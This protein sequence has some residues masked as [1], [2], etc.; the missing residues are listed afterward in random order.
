MAGVGW[1]VKNERGD[2][3]GGEGMEARLSPT[4]G[5]G[6][7]ASP[8]AAGSSAQ[9]DV[10]DAPCSHASAGESRGGAAAALII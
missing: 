3:A 8:S 4:H 10:R 7:A 6:G 2:R 5:G 1:I 9:R